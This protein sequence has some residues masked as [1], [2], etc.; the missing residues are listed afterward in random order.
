MYSSASTDKGMD[1]KIF[2][3]DGSGGGTWSLSTNTANQGTLG[4]MQIAGRVGTDE[5][6]ACDKDANN[7]IYCFKSNTTPS[8]STPTNNLMTAST[9]TGI[10][11]SFDM[12]FEP[13][14]GNTGI[15]VY[16]DNTSTPK[17][18]KYNVSTST[19]DASATSIS[20]VGSVL[21]TVRL[22]TM[23]DSDDIMVLLADTNRDIYTVMWNGSSDAI[24]TTPTGKALTVHGTNG[25]A[26]TDFWYDFAWD[27]L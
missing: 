13:V 1:L 14:S 21:S 15:A 16:S 9:Y 7:D 6:Q 20:A 18:K 10:L 2:T 24:Y 11:R 25:S 23:P 3:A 27:K 22:K 19:W 17:L 4:A 8:W 5:F 12:D 26:T